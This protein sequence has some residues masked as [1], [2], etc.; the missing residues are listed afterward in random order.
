MT[1]DIVARL[2]EEGFVTHMARLPR[3]SRILHAAADEI[4][5]LRREVDERDR[6][7]VELQYQLRD[8]AETELLLQQEICRLVAEQANM[9]SVD[10]AKDR[11]WDCYKCRFC[12]VVDTVDRKGTCRAC[13]K[14]FYADE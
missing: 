4:E 3:E 14:D 9:T 13:N 1:D 5:R 10:V 8:A 6:R 7:C 11:G 2:R 12:G